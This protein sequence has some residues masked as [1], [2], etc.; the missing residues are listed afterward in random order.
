MSTIFPIAMLLLFFLSSSNMVQ[1]G[2]V[3]LVGILWLAQQLSYQCMAYH[4]D[5]GKKKGAR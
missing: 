1:P 2:W 5:H 3:L 4:L